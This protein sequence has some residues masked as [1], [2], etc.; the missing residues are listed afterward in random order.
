[1]HIGHSEVINT[2]LKLR[3]LQLNADR[4]A[5]TCTLPK[6]RDVIVCQSPHSDSSFRMPDIVIRSLQAAGVFRMLQPRRYGGAEIPINEF[7]NSQCE[8][9]KI[10]M[11]TGWLVGVMGILAFHLAL[12]PEAAQDD[13]WLADPDAL[14]ASSYMPKGTAVAVSDGFEL[15][16]HWQFASGADHADWFMLGG[17][18]VQDGEREGCVFLV[19]RRDV[20]VHDVWRPT[21]LKAT[22]SQDVTISQCFVPHHR[23]HGWRDRFFG[24]SAGLACNR[25]PLYRIPLPQLLMR[26]I[27]TPAI[28]ALSGLLDAVVA[29]NRARVGANGAAACDDPTVQLVLGE[30]LAD[31]DEMLTNLEASVDR[32][33]RHA[34]AGVD[35][36]LRDRM[37]MRLQTTRVADRCCRTAQRLFQCSGTSGLALDR[38]IGRYLADIQ[39]SRQHTANQFQGFG[40]ALGSALLGR[41]TEDLLL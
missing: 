6:L 10:D 18:I 9:S 23:L 28:G 40:R 15:S 36:P 7:F 16:G 25:A 38:P 32:L 3:S 30:A 19:P 34:E 20:E 1:M 17:I 8:L 11:S 31:I 26:V 13:V 35:A 37:V 27:S 39:A 4:T 29:H 33:M 12:F 14:I 2:G 22:G 5:T 24:R 41:E 21:G